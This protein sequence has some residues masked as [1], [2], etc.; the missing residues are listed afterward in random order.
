MGDGIVVV[1]VGDCLGQEGGNAHGVHVVAIGHGDGIRGKEALDGA[2]GQ[3]GACL[4]VEHAVGNAGK[5]AGGAVL[6]ENLGSGAEGA[7]GFGH[8]VNHEHILA[9]HVAARAD[10]QNDSHLGLF[11]CRSGQQNAALRGFLGLNV[12]DHNAIRQRLNAH[13]SNLLV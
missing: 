13:N 7:A 3:A 10:S 2:V 5:D 8:V 11:L 1:D 9:V 6:L 4:V 12:L